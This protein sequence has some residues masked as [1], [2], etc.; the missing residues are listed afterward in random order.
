MET[1]VAKDAIKGGE[2]LIRETEADE[3]F[4][5][6][7][8]S[9][10]QK[11]MAEAT[12]D[13]IEKEIKPNVDRMDSLE[14][15]FMPGVL[16]KAGELG[17]LGISIPEQYG[18]L[19]MSFNTSMLIADIV[20][21]AGSFSTAYGAHTGIAT[22]PILYYGNEEQ[23]NKYIPKLASGE[24]KGAYCLTEPDAGSD[25]NSGKTKAVLSSDGKHYL[26]TGQKMWISNG[27]FADFFIVFA[28]I[29]DDK[30]LT[31][32]L[33][34]RTFGGITM[35]EEEKKLGIKG[36][37]TRQIFFNDCPV[38]V[39]NML[40]DRENGFKIAV[41]ILNIGRIKLAA[42]VIGGCKDVATMS[43]QYA[44]DRKQ[45]GVSI[46]SFGAIQHKLAEMAVKTY[47][48]E[49]ACYR[50]GQNIDDKITDLIANGMPENE[51]KLKGVEQFAIECAILKVHGSEVLDFVVDEGVQVYGGMG[52]SE[53]AP[54]ARAYRDARITRIYEGTNEINRML[55][56]GMVLKRAMKGELDILQPAMAV[57]KELTSVPSF[58]SPDLTK[59]FAEEKEVLKNLKKAIL[60]VAG[61]AAQTF[62]PKL[63]DEQEILMCIAD[64]MIEVYVAESTLLRTEKL[65]SKTGES[66]NALQAKLARVY[67]AEAVEKVNR[68]GKEAIAGFVKGDEQKVMLM[69]LKRFTK[70]SPVNT[71]LLRREIANVM[72]EKSGYPLA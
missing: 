6:E 66:A 63:N 46:S 5:P 43:T 61:K 38:P 70:M 71:I 23:K 59:P 68:A 57:A 19:G 17:L 26:I 35:N 41:N 24:W 47:A 10:E 36:S 62:G 33:V 39:E 52:F 13:F 30:N 8:F 34:E 53:E 22:L 60:M 72:I 32:F 64:M 18:G 40:S 28:K 51:A 45:F 56:V 20:S 1:T 7:E 15:G 3:I 4:I 31:A 67:L 14:E 29:D 16:E 9:E 42:G 50:A 27:G 12:R 58:A 44:N 2:F 55:L 25:A 69:G 54:M 48:T 49:S 11:M 65:V 21:S 37:S